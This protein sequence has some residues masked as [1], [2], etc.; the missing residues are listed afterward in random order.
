MDLLIGLLGA[1]I[2]SGIMAIVLAALQRKWKKDDSHDERLDAL[3][4]A[5][6]V[7]MVYEV[8]SAGKQ[9][10]NIGEISVD[11]K[12]VLHEMYQAYKGLGGNGHLDTIIHEVDRLKVVGE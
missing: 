7:T 6:K 4:N 11:D 2:G 12:E 5:Q 9:Y 10:L 8:K 1:G 3:I